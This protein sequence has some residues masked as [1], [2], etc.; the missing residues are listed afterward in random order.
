MNRIVQTVCVLALSAAPLGCETQIER[1]VLEAPTRV[2]GIQV[3]CAG[4]PLDA[5]QDPRWAD[6]PLRAEIVGPSGVYPGPGEF[7][8]E[9]AAGADVLAVRCPGPWALF[10]L[11][12]GAYLVKAKLET[13]DE[14][15]QIAT[16]PNGTQAHAILQIAAPTATAALE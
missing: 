6:Y 13:G 5:G 3:V 15:R 9:T 12:P 2:A 8:V 7:H 1:L 11:A 4:A 10:K 14:A 16:A